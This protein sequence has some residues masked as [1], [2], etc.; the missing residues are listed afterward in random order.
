MRRTRRRHALHL[1]R[2]AGAPKYRPLATDHWRTGALAR[3]APTLRPTRPARL[4]HLCCS[5]AD[6]LEVRR[7][8]RAPKAV[9]KQEPGGGGAKAAKADGKGGKGGKGAAKGKG[10]AKQAEAEV[11]QEQGTAAAGG[12]AVK[13]EGGAAAPAPGSDGAPALPPG[14]P[15][16]LFCR[17]QVLSA[18]Y[19]YC[20][21][22]RYCSH[23]P[24]RRPIRFQWELAEV[25]ALKRKPSYGDIFGDGS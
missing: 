11:K 21:R 15:V 9:N 8:L 13:A 24:R 6:S 4:C 12:A 22:L 10:K 17:N 16:L 7:L 18:Q 1:L 25:E 19:V 2:F 20:G 14:T 3:T 23:D 5:A